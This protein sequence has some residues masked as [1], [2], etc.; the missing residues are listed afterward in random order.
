MNKYN[1]LTKEQIE[2]EIEKIYCYL[3]GLKGISVTNL[4]YHMNTISFLKLK[5]ELKDYA[6]PEE[7]SDEEESESEDGTQLSE[8][9]AEWW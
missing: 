3:K 6:T 9:E 8:K 5:L 4:N 7:D 1:N 2:L